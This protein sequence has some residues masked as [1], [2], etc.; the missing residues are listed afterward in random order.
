MPGRGRGSSPRPGFPHRPPERDPGLRRRGGGGDAHHADQVRPVKGER[1]LGGADADLL[2]RRPD[3]GGLDR[4]AAPGGDVERRGG[5][6]ARRRRR[7]G[8]RRARVLRLVGD[9]PEH[10]VARD[11]HPAAVL[12]EPD[13]AALLDVPLDH[14]RV[15][16]IDQVDEVGGGPLAA[17]AFRRGGGAGGGRRRHGAASARPV[18]IPRSRCRARRMALTI[19]G[20]GHR[21]QRSGRVGNGRHDACLRVCL[22]GEG[23]RV[24]GVSCAL[25]AIAFAAGT[26]SAGVRARR[27]TQVLGQGR[28]RDRRGSPFWQGGDGGPLVGSV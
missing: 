17:R 12:L 11:P 23:E 3:R 13:L 19:P 6:V 10:L 2:T 15:A 9:D 1:A 7:R 16:C 22:W 8:E 5:G 24:L 28:G 27:A 14:D 26:G 25:L 18:P 21:V 4:R 20:G